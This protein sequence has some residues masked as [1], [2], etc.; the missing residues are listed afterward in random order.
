MRDTCDQVGGVV[1]DSNGHN[2]NYGFGRINAA[3]SVCEAALLVELTTP[4]IN[5]NDIPSGETTVRAVVFSVRSC[6]AVQLQIVSGPTTLTGA[7]NSFGTPIGTSVSLG[8][9]T[10]ITPRT[11]R[12]WISYTATNNGD[13][14][15]GTV[16]I[17]CTQTAQKWTIPITANTISRPKAAV[18]MVLD[19]SGSMD[20]DGGDGRKRIQ[21]LKDAAPVFAEVIQPDNA[22]GIVSFDQDAYDVMPITPAGLETFGAGRINAKAAISAHTPNPSGTTSI[23][24]GVD[25]AHQQLQPISG[26]DVKAMIVLTDGQ[27]N[28]PKYI[29][30]IMSEINERV[31]AIGLGTAE[32][33]NPVALTA[34][35][36]G[37]GGY[38]LL[39]GI[40]DTD[41][42]FRLSKYYL[43]ILAGVT[44]TEIVLDPEGWLYPDQVHRIPLQLNEADINSDIILLTPNPR[45]IRFHLETPNGD[46]IDP[47][48]VNPSVKYV[49]GDGV[50]YYRINLPVAVA[51]GAAHSGTW[52]AVLSHQD[53]V[54]PVSQ[55]TT[56]KQGIRY[57]LN[58]HS[59]S[60]LRMRTSLSQNSY[61]P[62]AEITLRAVLSEYDLPVES[63]ATVRALLER[64]DNTETTL[65]FTEVEPGVFETKTMAPVPGIYRLRTLANGRTLR[66][67]AFTREQSLTAA[68]WKGGDEPL[69][70]SKGDTSECCQRSLQL[71][72][73]QLWLLALLVFISV[74]I[75][76]LML[77]K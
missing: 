26:Y 61:Q 44:N 47:T 30:D 37:T 40:L 22:L 65:S 18:V 55:A 53:I 57:S 24:D 51:S 2:D 19:K 59:Y 63:R 72:K 23:G 49:V 15:T 76:L 39:T 52:Y 43:Q 31:F 27:E 8:T 7:A 48:T 25:L 20:F 3:R 29:A 64:P 13:T 16:T 68:V 28:T 73:L 1:Y 38:L 58:V 14:A 60:N 62:G 75:S 67:R 35:T 5:F 77:I 69:P 70:T 10:E 42:Y 66:G 46:I 4:S 9:T 74:M 17:R 56:Q 12:I 32:Q 54:I 11:A 34:L 45:E 33:I 50:S 71:H 36:N 6:R 21:I 41:D